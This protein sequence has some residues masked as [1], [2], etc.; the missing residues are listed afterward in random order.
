[1]TVGSRLRRFAC[2]AF[3]LA[4]AALIF[5]E[6]LAAG[7][8]TRGDDAMQSGDA[9]AARRLYARA[10]WLDARSAIAADRLAFHL[11]MGHERSRAAQAIVIVSAALRSAPNDAAL[12]GDR[13]LARMQ[14]GEWRLAEGDFSAA[15]RSS[16]DVRYEHF[17]GRMAFRA[18]DRASAIFH[19]RRALRRDPG[20][21]PARA[22]LRKLG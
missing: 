14:L 4:V 20:F 2:A 17:A 21:A 7:V 3:A 18:G 9:D 6:P 11:V 1:M 12:L 10:L 5:R 15:A 22:F 19:E 13:A 8:V 16:G